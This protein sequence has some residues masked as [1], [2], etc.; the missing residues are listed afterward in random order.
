MR[1]RED[2]VLHDGC[3][4]AWAVRKDNPKLLADLNRFVGEHKKGTLLGNILFKRYYQNTK[5]VRNPLRIEDRPRLRA[6]ADQFRK[7][8]E[9]YAFD[10]L[11][12]AAQAYQESGLDPSVRSKAGAVGIM[13][14][15]PST[16][17]DMGIT[18]IDKTENNIHAG[19]KYMAWLREKYFSE[20]GLSP[21]A[22]W[23]FCLAAYNA[24]PNRVV[25][26]R[27]KAASQGLDPNK[28]FNNVEHIAQHQVGQETPRYVS[29]I[30]KYYVAYTLAYANAVQRAA[31]RN[32]AG[33]TP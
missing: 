33:A 19:A 12:L 30:N 7:Y 21:E 8:G 24:G 2:L 4:I 15:L 5:W 27:K 3:E 14:L 23:D 18:N 9:Q 22:R 6:L 28:W 26:W 32:A 31:D 16:A 1:L 10:W 20:P 25:G 29:N 11:M 17:K 13:Q